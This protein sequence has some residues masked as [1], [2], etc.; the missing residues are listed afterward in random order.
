MDKFVIF[1]FLGFFF[2][3]LICLGY[4]ESDRKLANIFY[5][6]IPGR[7]GRPT[8]VWRVGAWVWGS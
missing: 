4:G 7:Q 1:I 3:G 6:Y 8:S 2:L 5:H